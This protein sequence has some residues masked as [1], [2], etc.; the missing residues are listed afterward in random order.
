MATSTFT[1]LP[2]SAFASTET[3]R[4]IR[5]GQPRTAKCDPVWSRGTAG[6]QKDLGSIPLRLSFLFKSCDLW[7]LSYDFVPHN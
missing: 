4:I 7:T 3:L 6:K 5:D 1:Q 2:S